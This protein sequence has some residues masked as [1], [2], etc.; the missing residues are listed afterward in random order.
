MW[1]FC[2]KP[3]M[4]NDARVASVCSHIRTC[5]R[6][7]NKMQLYHVHV[8]GSFFCSTASLWKRD[9]EGSEKGRWREWK[10]QW[11]KWKGTVKGVKGTVKEVKRDSEGSERDSEGSEKGKWREWKGQWGEWKGK[12]KGVKG[13]VKGVKRDNEG[14][15]CCGGLANYSHRLE[16]C[17][18]EFLMSFLSWKWLSTSL[19]GLSLARVTTCTTMI[20]CLDCA[21]VIPK[22]GNTSRA[23]HPQDYVKINNLKAKL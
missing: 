12:V 3:H 1:S 15:P 23:W 13:T 14:M 7:R 19:T 4:L 9:S 22:F 17:A 5:R 11:R 18:N 20:T 16:L 2:L 8:P 10:G 21:F 6:V